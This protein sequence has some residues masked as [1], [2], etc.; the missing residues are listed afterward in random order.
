MKVGTYVRTFE[1]WN[2]SFQESLLNEN[3]LRNIEYGKL[4]KL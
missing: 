3:I 1:L 2:L 4:V